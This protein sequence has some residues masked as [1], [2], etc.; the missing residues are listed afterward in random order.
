MWRIIGMHKDVE[1]ILVST[2]EIAERIQVL[3]EE[4]TADYQDKNPIV[5]GI[6]KGSVPFMSDLI[7][8]MDVKLQIDFMDISSYGGGVESSG[9]VKI[10]KD[11][12][13]D[14]SGRHVIIVED[15]V[16][17]G[18]TLAKIHDLFQHRNAASVK[19]VTLLNKPERRTA[20]VSVD[21]IG[22]EIPD[23]FVIGYGM[24]FD[25][26]YRQ[27]PYIGI[28]KPSVYAHLFHN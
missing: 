4:L 15:I 3:G 14:V 11:L 24:D 7:R 18:N 27:L 25:E 26:E 20:D 17:T 1:E 22:F 5:V 12:D 16:D 19:V 21:Y 28:L 2:E 6:L 13:A 23:K 9:Q 10:L 8:A